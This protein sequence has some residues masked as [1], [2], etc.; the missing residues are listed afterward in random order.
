MYSSEKKNYFVLALW[1]IFLGVL[2]I[3]ILLPSIG[4][5]K[6]TSERIVF[7]KKALSFFR[8]R[9]E[10]F[11]NIE[12]D[13]PFYQPVIE[14]IG[15][16]FVDLEVPV[17]FIEF[18]ERTAKDFG[19]IIKVSPFNAPFKEDD[20]WLSVGFQISLKGDFSDYLRFLE[21]L[22]QS[23]WLVEILQLNIRKT[24]EDISFNLTLKVFSNKT[25]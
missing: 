4:E 25:R 21:K 23:S 1:L 7:Q 6:N 11:E 13:Y 14:K 20:I 18:L 16:S 5:V 15:A 22:E 9:I 17:K 2:I 12:K 3:L 19:L 24:K 8:E 10:D